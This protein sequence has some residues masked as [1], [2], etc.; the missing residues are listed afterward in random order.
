VVSR[1]VE[2][3]VTKFAAKSRMRKK[4]FRSRIFMPALS[5]VL[6]ALHRV[7]AKGMRETSPAVSGE[8][9]VYWPHMVQMM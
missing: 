8:R 7:I 3:A 9:C 5:E 1:T 6:P 4:T 2:D